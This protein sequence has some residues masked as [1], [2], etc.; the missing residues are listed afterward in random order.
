MFEALSGSAPAWAWIAFHL[1]IFLMLTLDLGVLNRK[2]EPASWSIFA[3]G[4]SLPH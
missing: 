3:R 4:S 1:L 2:P